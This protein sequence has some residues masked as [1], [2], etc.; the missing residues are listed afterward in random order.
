[1]SFSFIH[2]HHHLSPENR[3]STRGTEVCLLKDTDLWDKQGELS[4]IKSF[5][6]SAAMMWG[7][8]KGEVSREL[9]RFPQSWA[10]VNA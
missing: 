7:Q 10:R 1:M 2:H 9:Q 6:N 5:P 4:R 3:P 8:G